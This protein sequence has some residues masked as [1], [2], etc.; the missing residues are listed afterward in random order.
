MAI[1]NVKY[2]CSRP[3]FWNP[4]KVPCPSCG[5]KLAKKNVT[6]ILRSGSEEANHYDLSSP[7][8]DGFLVGDTKYTEAQYAC[9]NCG[10]HYTIQDLNQI[11]KKK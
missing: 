3:L 10:T 4:E 1:Q 6:V 2:S 7:G 5:G 9:S 8:G 11:R